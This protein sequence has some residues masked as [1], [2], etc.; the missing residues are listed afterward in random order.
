MSETICSGSEEQEAPH[1][2]NI[3]SED[4]LSVNVRNPFIEQG[5]L[6]EEGFPE[7]PFEMRYGAFGI[8]RFHEKKGWIPAC[9]YIAVVN[10][11]IDTRLGV[12]GCTT[13]HFDPLGNVIEMHHKSSD[14]ISQKGSVSRLMAAGLGVYGGGVPHVVGF[15]KGMR[16]G[17]VVEVISRIGWHKCMDGSSVYARPSGIIGQKSGQDVLFQPSNASPIYEA[18]HESG[19]LQDWQ[20]HVHEPLSGSPIPVL[21]QAAALSG[22][23]LKKLGLPGYALDINGHS[24]TGKTLSIQS[25]V[26]VVGNAEDSTTANGTSCIQGLRATDNAFEHLAAHSNDGVLAV[27]E[28]GN[29]GINNLDAFLYSLQEGSGKARMNMDTTLRDTMRWTAVVLLSGE[30]SIHDFAK[31]SNAGQRIRVLDIPVSNEGAIRASS[32]E[33]AAGIAISV[34]DA[35]SRY[36]GT[37]GPALINWL[38]EQEQTDPDFFTELKGRFKEIHQTVIEQAMTAQQR[39]GCQWFSVAILA[40]ELACDSGVFIHSKEHYAAL[41]KEVMQCWLVDAEPVSNAVRAVTALKRFVTCNPNKFPAAESDHGR[42]NGLMGFKDRHGDY[43]FKGEDLVEAGGDLTDAVS[44]ARELNQLGLLRASKVS[45]DSLQS[46]K[47]VSGLGRGLYYVIH[48]S[49]LADQE[50]A[51]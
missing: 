9:D 10:R 22:L 50:A 41:I 34:K 30:R 14:L 48:R 51:T 11:T 29:N 28:T 18:Y 46:R 36:Y 35:C 8:E 15:I 44:I 3:Q 32:T 20:E 2:V 33:E 43:L 17:K 39:R 45:R 24:S 26:S 25:G 7:M 47:T 37:A 40:S 38:I 23:L 16:P 21:A 13:W 49:F 1:E 31:R 42:P 19:S 12:W 6:P 4:D 27:D 5:L